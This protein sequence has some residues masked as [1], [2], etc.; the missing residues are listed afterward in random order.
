MPTSR[1]AVPGTSGAPGGYTPSATPGG[2]ASGHG[3]GTP[4]TPFGSLAGLL[5]LGGGAQGTTGGA[6]SPQRART[7]EQ[8]GMRMLG[9][10]GSPLRPGAPPSTL[11]TAGQNPMVA[12]FQQMFGVDYQTALAMMAMLHPGGTT[13]TPGQQSQNI[14]SPGA[15]N[16]PSTP[17]TPNPLLPPSSMPTAQH[18]YGAPQW[19]RGRTAMLPPLGQGAF[20]PSGGATPPSLSSQM[21]YGSTA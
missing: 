16:P 8:L 6:M 21:L 11:S 15:F 3:T 5:G 14:F 7:I 2:V 13:M 17:P 20:M 19:Q 1:S 12:Q 10:P 9:P 4:S 18:P